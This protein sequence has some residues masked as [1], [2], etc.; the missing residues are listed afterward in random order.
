MT[1]TSRTLAAALAALSL[2]FAGGCAS[3]DA[4]E[5]DVK[6]GADD[7]ERAIDGDSDKDGK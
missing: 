6:N 7:V 1:I 4:V 3:D 5:K 2:A